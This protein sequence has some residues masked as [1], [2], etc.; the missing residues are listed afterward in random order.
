[1]QISDIVLELISLI[2]ANL[3]VWILLFSETF[4]KC[5]LSCELHGVH[6]KHSLRI[7]ECRIV[8]NKVHIVLYNVFDISGN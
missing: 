2:L 1:M 3:F 4:L 5:P 8:H 6:W 7:L